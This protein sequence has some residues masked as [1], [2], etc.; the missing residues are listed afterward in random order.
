MPPVKAILSCVTL[1]ESFYSCDPGNLYKKV[2]ILSF[3]FLK[4]MAKQKQRARTAESSH[5]DQQVGRRGGEEEEGGGENTLGNRTPH[6]PL[7][8][9]TSS[10]KATS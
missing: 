3:K 2:L 4:V 10:N 6:P 5:L 9:H 8:G 7:P 1:Y